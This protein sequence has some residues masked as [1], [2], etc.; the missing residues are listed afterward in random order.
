MVCSLRTRRMSYSFINLLCILNMSAKHLRKSEVIYEL[1]IRNLPHEGSV[2]QNRKQYNQALASNVEVDAAA[3]NTLD[4]ESELEECGSK[5]KDLTALVQDY[6]GT[7]QNEEYNRIMARLWHLYTRVERI[8]T[9]AAAEGLEESKSELQRKSKL[10]LDGFEKAAADVKASVKD[11]KTDSTPPSKPEKIFQGLPTPQE[12]GVMKLKQKDSTLREEQSSQETSLR[13]EEKRL[14]EEWAKLQ[15][16]KSLLF[17][18]ST[19]LGQ[20]EKEETN[21]EDRKYR[22][23]PVYKWGLKFDGQSQSIGSFLQRVEETRGAR[24]VTPEEVFD[25]AVDLFTGPA[26]TWYRSTHGR[27]STWERLCEE[28]KIVFQSPDHDIRLQQEIFNRVQGDTEPID[29]FIASMEGLY[30]RLAT[31]TPEE[32]RLHQISHNLNSHLQDRLAMFDMASI[33]QLRILGRKAEMGRFRSTTTTR[34]NAKGFPIVEPDLAYEAPKRK[35]LH[36]ASIQAPPKEVRAICWNCKEVGHRFRDCQQGKKIFC[37]GCGTPDV[38][39]SNC[40]K[41][42]RNPNPKN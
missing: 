5:L 11:D 1:K 20:P 3:V 41:C 13:E 38:Y 40:Q 15:E 17:R 6:E 28:M 29:L 36:L 42:S 9:G 24:G 10:L 12:L 35:Q 39:R 25:S 7:Y 33:E 32:I 23:V 21:R 30:G 14:Q 37:F 2:D 16:K 19:T 18:S 27:I 8:P 34:G 26:L 4:P 22:Y 31:S